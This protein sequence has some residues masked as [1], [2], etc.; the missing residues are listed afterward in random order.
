MRNTGAF[1]PVPAFNGPVGIDVKGEQVWISQANPPRVRVCDWYSRELTNCRN[2][3]SFN[4][5]GLSGGAG[6][7][8]LSE[9]RQRAYVAATY[10]DAIVYCN[11]TQLMTDCD[12]I[13]VSDS[14]VGL[15][16]G[17]DQL[18]YG[19]KAGV[20]RCPLTDLIVDNSTCVNTTMGGQVN[21]VWVD[22]VAR[23]LYLAQTALGRVMLCDI[24]QAL[25][26]T[27]CEATP[28]PK[29]PG[30]IGLDT[31]NSRLYVPLS[32]AGSS[33]LTVCT[34]EAQSCATSTYTLNPPRTTS[35]NVNIAHAMPP[36]IPGVTA[37]EAQM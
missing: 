16:V 20:M 29:G 31:F 37:A 5:T 34:A 1:G 36:V 6:Q 17:L 35:G 18:W 3:S 14:P 15:D 8:A 22:S 28:I 19:D 23:K 13:E 21:G 12:A 7:V 4:L 25:A 9:D 11:N 10:D 24:T 30:S 33:E 27:N 26:V 2:P 32:N